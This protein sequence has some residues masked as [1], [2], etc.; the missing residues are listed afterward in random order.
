MSKKLLLNPSI[1]AVKDYFKA[2]DHQYTIG[3]TKEIQIQIIIDKLL[4]YCAKK[5]DW[6]YHIQLR[7]EEN[8]KRPDATVKFQN[9]PVGYLEAKDDYTKDLSQAVQ[10]K[11]EDDDYAKYKDNNI[12]F[13]QPKES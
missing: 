13:W 7:D 8:N 2:I 12:M 3:E 11:F 1:K 9:V 10:K 5:V 6:T 4:E